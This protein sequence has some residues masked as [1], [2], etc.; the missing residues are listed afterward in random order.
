MFK[1]W[2]KWGTVSEK[3]ESIS[4]IILIIAS[5][6]TVIG[7]SVGSFYPGFPVALAIIGAFLVV[8]AI[9]LYII[10]EFA[11]I[12]GKKPQETD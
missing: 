6:F 7:I 12:L 2:F 3:I 5:V 10:S 9:A 4:F 11:G 8:V 1:D